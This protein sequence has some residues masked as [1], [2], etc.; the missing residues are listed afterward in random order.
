MHYLSIPSTMAGFA[1]VLLILKKLN[2]PHALLC[3]NSDFY[4]AGI[5]YF[6]QFYAWM[7]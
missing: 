6:D 5:P 1:S 3:I 2:K 4:I 7:V